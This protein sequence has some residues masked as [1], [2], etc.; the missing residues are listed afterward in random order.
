MLSAAT[1]AK[2]YSFSEFFF[3]S[4][5]FFTVSAV[6]TLMIQ[7]CTADK[8]LQSLMKWSLSS[9]HMHSDFVWHSV[10]FFS[11]THCALC[12]SLVFIAV[13]MMC[14]MRSQFMLFM[15]DCYM[16]I[17]LVVQHSW[18]T[19]F[20]VQFKL[21]L[22]CCHK[23]MYSSYDTEIEMTIK[24][25]VSVVSRLLLRNVFL[26]VSSY[27]K[28]SAF[29]SVCSKVVR[30]LANDFSF[31]FKAFKIQ[32]TLFFNSESLYMCWSWLISF[33]MII[34]FKTLFNLIQ[35]TIQGVTWLKV[36]SLSWLYKY[37]NCTLTL[38]CDMFTFNLVTICCSQGLNFTLF[39]LNLSESK[40]H[41]FE[42]WFTLIAAMSCFKVRL[43]IQLTDFWKE[44]DVVSQ[45]IIKM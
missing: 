21:W 14:S 34:W 38:L 30:C 11:D 3:F 9:Q 2:S 18:V 17:I 35:A 6:T 13:T 22:T 19:V 5:T 37:Q 24:A 23:I 10:I 42:C 8:S 40:R 20:W 32:V 28:S 31:C 15:W 1:S 36:N 27:F 45:F 25:H 12:L 33:S 29:N 16:M 4:V 39:S 43:F 26:T 44:D 7:D 41:C